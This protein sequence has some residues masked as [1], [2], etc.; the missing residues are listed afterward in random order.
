MRLK[1][2][3]KHTEIKVESLCL[4]GFYDLGSSALY[5]VPAYEAY[6]DLRRKLIRVSSTAVDSVQGSIRVW[7]N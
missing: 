7:N 2:P 4:A 5:Y 3:L 6:A 1:S